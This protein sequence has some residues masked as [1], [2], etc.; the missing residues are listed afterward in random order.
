MLMLWGRR[1][2]KLEVSSHLEGKLDEMCMEGV[3]YRGWNE[4]IR[5]QGIKES[6]SNS[7]L[8][9]IRILVYGKG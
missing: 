6:S 9:N 5:E 2:L 4:I 7:V 1:G 3:Y 8:Y